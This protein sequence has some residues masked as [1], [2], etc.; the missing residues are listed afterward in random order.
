[1]LDVLAESALPVDRIIPAASERS[2]GKSVT[3]KSKE[4]PIVTLEQALNSGAKL[5][6]FSAGGSVSKRVGPRF[7]EKD[8]L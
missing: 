5:A 7:A 8:L 3:F 6:L 1:M 2:L 4:Y